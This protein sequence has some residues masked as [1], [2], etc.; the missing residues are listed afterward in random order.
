ML[1]TDIKPGKRKT[2]YIYIDGEFLFSAYEDIIYKYSLEKNKEVERE[3]LILAQQEQNIMYAKNKALDILSR[4]VCSKKALF[5]K[6]I[7]KGICFLLI[8]V[9]EIERLCRGKLGQNALLKLKSITE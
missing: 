2:Y 7:T 1:I 5:Q 9:S 4:A 3:I 6:L 8:K